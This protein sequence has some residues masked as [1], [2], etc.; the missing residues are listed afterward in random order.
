MSQCPAP[1]TGELEQLRRWKDEATAVINV[2]EECYEALPSHGKGPLGELKPVIVKRWIEHRSTTTAID[3]A[4]L[5]R[6][7]EWSDRTFGPAL[8]TP[9]CSIT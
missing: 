7:G 4:H 5:I 6:L 3:V 8:D 2:W 1:A 9:A